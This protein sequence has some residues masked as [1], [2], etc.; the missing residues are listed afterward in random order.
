MKTISQGL[1]LVVSKDENGF[2]NYRLIFKRWFISQYNFNSSEDVSSKC[3]ICEQYVILSLFSKP[4]KD[5][6]LNKKKYILRI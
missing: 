1:L 5:L 3:E 4:Q 2:I 6:N